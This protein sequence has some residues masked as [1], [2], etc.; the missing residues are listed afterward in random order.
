MNKKLILALSLAF[1]LPAVAQNPMT[2]GRYEEHV[3][4]PDSQM[5]RTYLIRVRQHDDQVQFIAAAYTGLLAA[6]KP[7]LKQSTIDDAVFLGVQLYET[8]KRR[9]NN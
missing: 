7:S 3:V 8:N 4:G 9:E 6:G 2:F 5:F 1:A